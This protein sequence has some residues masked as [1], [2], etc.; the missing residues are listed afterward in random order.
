VRASG[1]R[2]RRVTGNRGDQA[3]PAM[4]TGRRVVWLD[5]SQGHTDLVTRVP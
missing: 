2:A 1:G 5:S 3:Y 4:A